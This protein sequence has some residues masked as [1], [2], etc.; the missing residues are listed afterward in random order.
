MVPCSLCNYYSYTWNESVLPRVFTQITLQYL[1]KM[2]SFKTTMDRRV[3]GHQFVPRYRHWA[4][5]ALQLESKGPWISQRSL[6][7]SQSLVILE[8]PVLT[9]F[10]CFKTLYSPWRF[11]QTSH[12]QSG[13]KLLILRD[14]R[15]CVSQLMF[16][17]L[18]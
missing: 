10:N 5:K 17:N 9:K 11:N 4:I 2:F 8:M 7:P 6:T 12:H 15:K 18:P 13:S 14:V 16:P 1:S 3:E